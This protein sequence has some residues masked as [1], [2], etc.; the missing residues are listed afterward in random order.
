MNSNDNLKIQYLKAK[1][2]LFDKKYSFLNEMQRRAVF[3]VK[4][5]L[6][7][8]A[9]AGSGKTT[10]LVNRIAYMIKYGNAYFDERVPD[11]ISSERINELEKALSLSDDEISD[12]LNEFICDA[13]PP[14]SVLSI[15]FT[16][17][18]ANEMK[19]R[20]E[21]MLGEYSKEV[22][23]GTFHSVCVRILHKYADRIG[24]SK[25]F[26]IYDTDDCKKLISSCMKELNID[27]KSLP[28]KSAI[29]AISHAKERLLSPDEYLSNE[30]GNDYRKKQIAELYSRYQNQLLY[31]NALDFDDIIMQTVLL[32]QKDEEARA[33]YQHRFKYVCVDEFQDTNRAQM[34][35]VLLLSGFHR[36]LMVVG[37]DD[38]SIYKFR[39]ATI[40]NILEFDR[41]LKDA[42]VIKLE[43]NYRSTQTI[44]DAA[45]AVV[46]RNVGRRD[47]VLWTENGVGELVSVK[48]LDNQI[49]EAKFIINKIMEL[50]IR[51]KRKFSDFAILYRVNAQSN[52]L[53]QVFARSGISY[54]IVGGTRFS[55]R[56][57]IRDVFAY[58]NLICN[59]R[60]DQRLKRIINEPKRKIGADTV[61]KIEYTARQNGI[62][63]FEVMDDAD[64]YPI[65]SKSA[66]KLKE[67]T[68]VIKK[69][70]EIAL[71]SEL[72]D[73]IDSTLEL[74]GY[75]QMLINGGEAEADRLRNV[76]E[77]L[78]N[79]I[80]YRDSHEEPTLR[81][82]LDEW[83]LIS[84]IDNYD[85]EADAVVLMT[86]HSA[87]G[88]E[89]PVVFLPGMEENIFP[90]VQSILDPDEL[91]EERRLAYVA[92]TRA[93]DRLFISHVRQRMLYG[94]TQYNPVSRFVDEIPDELKEIDAPVEAPKP[95]SGRK[96]TTISKEF[97]EKASITSG[98]GRTKSAEKFAVGDSV[99]HITFGVGTILS[100]R[101]MGADILYEIAFDNVGT[102][103]LMAT[104]AKLRKA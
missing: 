95:E 83:A 101:E 97:S 67:F 15:T 75:R 100:V 56:K 32:L 51:E 20:L 65:I 68:S 29:N 93:K 86:I 30:G 80:E 34:E 38:Q 44:L 19:E 17:K 18:T 37:D 26:T 61:N 69:L 66:Y 11:D 71:T 92:I 96:K 98:V 21:R 46:R 104:Y 10:V 1:R 14:W 73:I 55:D 79:A 13:C 9:G 40:E 90:G 78:S 42:E 36:N 57:E 103:K 43:Q 3:T 70:S 49:N 45:N 59:H 81:G 6:L 77:L 23:S 76:S 50:V 33:Y 74:T 89:F 31:S 102:K 63:M 72:P 58:L 53:E 99:Q 16:N 94:R 91:E 85:S 82:F 84:D 25:N 35:L 2:A 22:W 4:N 60:D 8:L 41:K 64:K 54:R 7:I 12:I 87:K 52:S 62:S 5:P 47:K 88:L 27:E 28:V 48:Q 24:Y 39:G